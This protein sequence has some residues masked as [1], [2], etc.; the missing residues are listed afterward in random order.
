MRGLERHIA[1]LEIAVTQCIVAIDGR[2]AATGPEAGQLNHDTLGVL[3]DFVLIRQFRF[4][5]LFS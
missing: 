4:A 2:L 1:A 5:H 3:N